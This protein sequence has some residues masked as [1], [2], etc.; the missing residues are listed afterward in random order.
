[1]RSEKRKNIAGTTAEGE[2]DATKALVSPVR[3]RIMR[4]VN[5]QNTGPEIRL[6][7]CLWA[8]GLRYRVHPKIFGTTPDLAFMRARV[9]VFVDGCFWH[10]CPKHYR[11]PKSNVEFWTKKLAQNQL[12]DTRDRLRLETAD[13]TVLRVWQ[14][15]I[16]KDVDGVR[17]RIESA[18]RQKA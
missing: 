2:E 6:R 8:S 18:V 13:W 17:R 10:G 3:S 12:R 5:S 9:A 7:R 1:V 4:S 15:E 11:L 14:C 16:K